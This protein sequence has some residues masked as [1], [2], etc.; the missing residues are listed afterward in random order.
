MR[1]TLCIALLHFLR[2]EPGAIYP[3]Q[4]ISF[5]EKWKNDKDAKKIIEEYKEKGNLDSILNLFFQ[6]EFK[7]LT[8]VIFV[9]KDPIT[10][11]VYTVPKERSNYDDIIKGYYSDYCYNK[12]L[13]YNYA[14]F[15]KRIKNNNLDVWNI[16]ISKVVC[17]KEEYLE[18]DFAQLIDSEPVY[19]NDFNL[20]YFLERIWGYSVLVEKIINEQKT[21]KRISFD[22]ICFCGVTYLSI[23]SE[24][25]MKICSGLEEISAR[26]AT[27][28]R[29]VYVQNMSFYYKHKDNILHE[30]NGVYFRNAKFFGAVYI[31]NLKFLGYTDMA[32]FSFEDAHICEKAEI[33]NVMFGN[34]KLCFFQTVIENQ[35]DEESIVLKNSQFSENAEIDFTGMEIK[36][37]QIKLINMEYLPLIKM[38]FEYNYERED[39]VSPD[40]FV[41]LKNCKIY[42]PIYIK[43]ISKLSFWKTYNFRRIVEEDDWKPICNGNRLVRNKKI[44]KKDKIRSNLI[45]AVFNNDKNDYFDIQ[46]NLENILN[47]S[48]AKD[49]V[50]LKENFRMTGEYEREDHAFLL[51]MKYKSYLDS[52]DKEEG[53]EYVREIKV[54][55]FMYF[56]LRIVGKYGISPLRIFIFLLITYS[57]SFVIDEDCKVGN[58]ILSF[59]STFL[60]G[61][62]SVAV[63]RKTLH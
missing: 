54:T 15:T 35:R 3:D 7:S 27:F 4:I 12:Y 18:I 11:A 53:L 58:A 47:F 57:F 19:F 13:Y 34:L 14:R 8:P 45:I 10:K 37:T 56:I 59:A 2:T 21:V 28:E 63:V 61:Y 5:V 51:H 16:P 38:R 24:E 26:A 36:T 29:D 48:K 23:E 1:K 32:A 43:N 62:F 49:F 9:K 6:R 30:H 46:K 44:F 25:G 31:R 42:N 40:V 17:V 20:T 39:G 41:L 50:L 33:N 52:W 60:F 22:G 55:K